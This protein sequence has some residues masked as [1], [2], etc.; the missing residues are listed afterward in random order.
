MKRRNR[1]SPD[2]RTPLNHQIILAPSKVSV[3]ALSARVEQRDKS[4]AYRV[5]RSRLRVLVA[6]ARRAGPGQFIRRVAAADRPGQNMLAIKRR[7]REVGRVLAVLTPIPCSVVHQTTDGPWDGLAS[8]RRALPSQPQASAPAV[9]CR[10]GALAPPG[11][12]LAPRSAVRLSRRDAGTR[13]GHAPSK[14][15][16]RSSR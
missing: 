16:V 15:P 11:L 1:G 12:A 10:G 14:S 4:A 13:D 7:T 9:T 6:V 8:H 2:S 3:P 5:F